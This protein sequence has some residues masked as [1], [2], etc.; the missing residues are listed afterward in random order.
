M[1]GGNNG[2][3]S[4]YVYA[5]GR[6]GHFMYYSGNYSVPRTVYPHTLAI[7]DAH[8]VAQ[9][10]QRAG[11]LTI[12]GYSTEPECWVTIAGTEL[13]PDLRLDI[14]QASGRMLRLWLEID[15]G[16]EGQRQ[17]RGKLEAYWRAYRDADAADWPI[18]PA[19]L[20]VAVDAERAKELAWL[21]SQGP[22]EAQ[23]LF[24][25][26]TFALLSQALQG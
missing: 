9:R 15:M 18:F 14:T 22:A 7:A 13:R 8:L 5:L 12:V 16:S 21:I 6:R 1:I 25:V 10:L 20:F 24:S 3:A 19:V 2:G 4:Q 17:I 26:T 23:A 11:L